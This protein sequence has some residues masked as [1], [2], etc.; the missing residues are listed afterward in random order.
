MS[1]GAFNELPPC[2]PIEKSNP[3]SGSRCEI[4]PEVL[5]GDQIRVV[6]SVQNRTKVL[7]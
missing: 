3:D 1:N 4:I 6:G 7:V 5:T 2:G